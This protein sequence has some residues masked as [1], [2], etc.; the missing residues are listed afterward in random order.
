MRNE[1]GQANDS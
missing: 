1:Q